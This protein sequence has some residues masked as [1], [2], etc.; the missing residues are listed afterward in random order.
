MRWYQNLNH[1]YMGVVLK[2][3]V[4]RS[5]AQVPLL[6]RYPARFARAK[7][8]DFQVDLAVDTMPSILETCGAEI[9]EG[10]HGVSYLSLLEGNGDTPTRERV[11]IALMKAD[12]G[13]RSERHVNPERGIPTKEWLF[14]RKEDRPL[15]LFDQL[16]DRDEVHNLVNDP[17]CA[18]VQATHD[19][20]MLRNMEATGDALDLEMDFPPPEYTT[21][22]ERDGIS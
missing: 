2:R 4:Y 1:S 3:R 15:Y 16:D 7:Y 10:V 17:V 19:T 12:I 20:R 5:S 11:Q 9:P 14:V 6:I 8:V 21:H 13:G 18:E 22:A